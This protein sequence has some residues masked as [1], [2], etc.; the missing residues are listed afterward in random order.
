MIQ[1]QIINGGLRPNIIHAYSSGMFVVRSSSRQRR[2]ALEERVM[3]CFEAGALASGATSKVTLKR[4]YD[5]RMPNK[6]LG[7]RFRTAFTAL[8]GEIP[9]PELDVITAVT[10]AS[11]D[12]R[13][14]SY[15]IP[16]IT[17]GDM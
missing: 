5:D 10:M 6:T 8:G 4:S 13:N 2:D 3:A 1:C 14:V 9:E 15:A 16:S 11:T 17:V 7:A 12:Q